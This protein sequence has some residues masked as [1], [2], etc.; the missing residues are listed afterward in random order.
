MFG[1]LWKRGPPNVKDGLKP[2]KLNRRSCEP[3]G[4][5]SVYTVRPNAAPYAV[6]HAPYAVLTP[7][8]AVPE[9]SVQS[10]LKLVQLYSG[11]AG[12][13]RGT[14]CLQYTVLQLQPE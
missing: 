7:F 6:C 5:L 4:M 8:S 11:R 13:G 3:C 12:A 2:A 10:N 1:R 14:G 9:L